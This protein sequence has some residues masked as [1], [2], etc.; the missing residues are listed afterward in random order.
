MNEE[1]NTTNTADNSGGTHP[2]TATDNGSSQNRAN[3][4]GQQ[5]DYYEIDY[6]KKDVISS[7]GDGEMHDEGLA[8]AGDNAID[9]QSTADRLS[10]KQDQAESFDSE[11]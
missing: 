6:G 4:A 2:S 8:G 1:K 5:D 9:P 10:N 11:Q 3:D 7:I